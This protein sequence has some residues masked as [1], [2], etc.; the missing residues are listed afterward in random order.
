MFIP[1]FNL[2]S[3]LSVSYSFN[4]PIRPHSRRRFCILASSANATIE[5]GNGA[6]LAPTVKL[7]PSSYG[8]QYFPL[9]A[10]VGQVFSNF[11][12]SMKLLYFGI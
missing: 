5:S 1:S 12:F 7:E 2:Q 10:V 3:L 4:L 11:A 6:V 8:R 9:A